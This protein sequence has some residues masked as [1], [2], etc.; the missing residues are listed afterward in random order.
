VSRRRIA[1]VSLLTLLLAAAAL[2]G[3]ELGNGAG[4]YGEEKTRDA[5][6]ARPA[7]P[8]DGIDAT[9]QRIAIAGLYGAACELG[10]SREELVLSFEP[11]LA[12]S[13]IRWSHETIERAVR[14][15]LLRAINDADERGSLPGFAAFILREIVERAPIDWLLDRAGDIAGLFG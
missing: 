12:P 3:V 15:G 7:Y 4:S 6:S 2:L 11:S 1:V 5:C 8:G 9:L 10:A 13:D 14:S